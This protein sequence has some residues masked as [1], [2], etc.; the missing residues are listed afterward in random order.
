MM[1]QDI[2]LLLREQVSAA[3][4]S[5]DT[6]FQVASVSVEVPTLSIMEW[7]GGEC[8]QWVFRDRDT[9][10]MTAGFGQVVEVS[11]SYF[12]HAYGLTQMMSILEGSHPDVRF[13]GGHQFGDGDGESYYCWYAIPQLMLRQSADRCQI[14]YFFNTFDGAD[15]LGSFDQFCKYAFSSESRSLSAHNPGTAPLQFI[16]DYPTWCRLVEEAQAAIGKGEVSK[17]VLAR[18]ALLQ[19]KVSG[20]EV[21]KRCLANHYHGFLFW[22]QFPAPIE[23]QEFFGASPE[24]LFSRD[25]RKVVSEAIA[26]TASH[27]EIGLID[28]GKDRKEHQWVLDM[29][30]SQLNLLCDQVSEPCE[31]SVI[32][33]NG[34]Q[35]LYCRVS[36]ILR[37]DVTDADI[38]LK[39]HP[40]P[41]VCGFPQ[42]EA[43]Q[44]LNDHEPFKR[45]FYSGSVGLFGAE[46]SS[47]VVAIR[48]GSVSEQGTALYTGA[49]IVSDSDAHLEWQELDL[50]LESLLAVVW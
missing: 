8:P 42:L 30:Q 10:E 19:G 4:L 20:L 33:G 43:L 1:H 29:V 49:G 7:M 39:L 12:Q 16:P 41:A 36:G 40:T 3:A 17:V 2:Y 15:L 48:C 5:L 26:G 28:R 13:F 27:G 18:Q 24:L 14:F 22:I 9:L 25:G 34:V 32:Q 45:G 35:H 31:L 21:I 23:T 50:K 6:Q 38:L 44:F 11:G 47:V 46:S 37:D